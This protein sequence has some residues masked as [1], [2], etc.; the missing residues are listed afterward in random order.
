VRQLSRIIND[1]NWK[2]PWETLVEIQTGGSQPPLFLVHGA[3]GNV[4]L[5]RALATHLGSNQPVYGFQSQGLDG[6]RPVVTTVEEMASL[7][8]ERLKKAYPSGPYM[9]GGYCMG[10]SVALEMAQKLRAQGDEV[11]LLAFFETYNYSKIKPMSKIDN[12]HSYIQKVDFHW[13]NFC[14][15]SSKEKWHFV[16]EKAKVAVAR[17]DVWLGMLGAKLEPLF[18]NKNGQ[19]AVLAAIWETNDQAAYKYVPKPY[20]GKVT[21]F[22]PIREYVHH[23]GPELGWESIANAGLETYTLPVYP[24]GMLVEPFVRLLAEKL[25]ICINTA[26]GQTQ[27]TSPPPLPRRGEGKGEGCR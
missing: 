15:L 25:T 11:P 14:L 22:L 9:L 4:L 26:L 19:A 21:Q 5:Y 12:L 7:Y 24:A 23:K 6:E 20:S 8:V 10:G 2:A 1:H 27:L 18:G 17:K 3:G 13:R 16:S